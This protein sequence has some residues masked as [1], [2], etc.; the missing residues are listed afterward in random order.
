M[1]KFVL[2]RP[3]GKKVEKN[4]VYRWQFFLHCRVFRTKM[5]LGVSLRRRERERASEMQLSSVPIVG[6]LCTSSISTENVILFLFHFSSCRDTIRRWE[7]VMTYVFR[8]RVPNDFKC[9]PWNST[10]YALSFTS[11]SFSLFGR[12][13]LCSSLPSS[14]I[15]MVFVLMWAVIRTTFNFIFTFL[16]L[17]IPSIKKIL[18]IF[19]TEKTPLF[20]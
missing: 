16:F 17:S 6:F 12:T 4:L 7:Q 5:W 14:N 15:K 3:S 11:F 13:T 9:L 2:H 10:T 18:R 8:K 19:S 20:A 1:N